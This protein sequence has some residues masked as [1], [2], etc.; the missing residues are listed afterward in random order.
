MSALTSRGRTRKWSSL[1]IGR[2]CTS[3]FW[4][5]T[6]FSFDGVDTFVWSRY[7]WRVDG[8]LK[9]T[10]ALATHNLIHSFLAIVCGAWVA[11]DGRALFCRLF[12]RRGLS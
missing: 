8:S 9:K 10:I 1:F 2:D 6:N 11:A 3:L 4:S 7:R 12:K 5:R